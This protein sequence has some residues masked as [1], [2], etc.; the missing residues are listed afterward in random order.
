[1]FQSL[2]CALGALAA[3]GAIAVT[4]PAAEAEPPH[5]HTDS[6][7]FLSSVRNTRMDGQRTLYL[8]GGGNAI[9]RLDFGA[10][11]NN[12]GNEPLVFHPVA[13][14]GQICHAIDLDVSVRGT[15]ERCMATDLRRLTPEEAAALPKSVR[16]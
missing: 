15:G 9:Y 11:C 8:R 1:M 2:R 13:N 4:L 14:T 10:D 3:L 12:S 6:C 7:F 5:H 16:P